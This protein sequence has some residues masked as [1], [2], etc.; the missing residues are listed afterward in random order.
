PFL[1]LCR[2]ADKGRRLL[3]D[4]YIALII[5]E[6]MLRELVFAPQ[7]PQTLAG[8]LTTRGL[9]V[10]PLYSP[11]GEVRNPSMFYGRDRELREMIQAAAPQC[12]L[13][14][15]RR[16]GKSSLLHRLQDE[17]SRQRPALQIVSR[18]LLGTG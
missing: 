18:T 17:D 7:P 15:P 6:P 14:G 12:L 3:P 8:L 9:L 10:L 13:V 2:D 16:I 4:G 5:D 1:M 11:D